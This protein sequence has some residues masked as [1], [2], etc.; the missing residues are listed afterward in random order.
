MNWP[1]LFPLLQQMVK[2][3]LSAPR[4]PLDQ[5]VQGLDGLLLLLCKATG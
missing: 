4:V 5:L 2:A 1:E 3:N